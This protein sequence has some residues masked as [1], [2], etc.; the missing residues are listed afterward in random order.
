M[1]QATSWSLNEKAYQYSSPSRN[2][3]VPS[4]LAV[5]SPPRL[6]SDPFLAPVQ[7]EAA[8]LVAAARRGRD[9]L[10][11]DAAEVEAGEAVLEPG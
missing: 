10:R 2:W 7:D 9:D 5:Q 1:P 3:I 8:D 4:L 6:S 11:V